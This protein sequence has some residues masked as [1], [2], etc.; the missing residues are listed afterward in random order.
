M[1]W[2][3]AQFLLPQQTAT[4]SVKATELNTVVLA[5]VSTSILLEVRLLL[6]R[7]AQEPEHQPPQRHPPQA[8][9]SEWMLVTLLIRCAQQKS[10]AVL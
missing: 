5:V 9:P 2:E 10:P 4:W 1:L 7:A 8:L 3:L 6:P